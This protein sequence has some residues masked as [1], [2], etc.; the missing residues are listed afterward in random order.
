MPGGSAMRE[1]AVRIIL[2]SCVLDIDQRRRGCLTV[3]VIHYRLRTGEY[4]KRYCGYGIDSTP[5]S[6]TDVGNMIAVRMRSRPAG[7]PRPVSVRVERA[8]AGGR[9]GAP[10]ALRWPLLLLPHGLCAVVLL[11]ARPGGRGRTGAAKLAG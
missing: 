6:N 9:A 2:A 7:R 3:S 4:L 10:L 1:R 11:R 8:A 5:V